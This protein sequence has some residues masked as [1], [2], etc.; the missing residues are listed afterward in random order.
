MRAGVTEKLFVSA[1]AEYYADPHEV[2]ISTSTAN[3]FQTFGFSLNFDYLFT[4]NVMWRLEART[5]NSRD[6]IFYLDEMPAQ[7][8]YFVGTSIAFS[9]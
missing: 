6:R 4:E 5:F 1:R 8:N 2:I 3:G 7:N 9:F